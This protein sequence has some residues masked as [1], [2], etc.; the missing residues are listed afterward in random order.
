MSLVDCNIEL[1]EIL[2]VFCV[3]VVVSYMSTPEQERCNEVNLKC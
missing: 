2:N 1:F 3:N